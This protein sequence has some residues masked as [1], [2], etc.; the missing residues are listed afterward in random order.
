MC[1]RRYLV[2]LFCIALSQSYADTKSHSRQYWVD[3]YLSVSYP[4]KDVKVNSGYGGRKDPFSGN[5]THHSGLDLKANYER[6]MAMF[7]GEVEQV[8]TDKRSGHYIVLRHHIYTVSYCHLSKVLVEQGD[9]VYAGDVVGISGDT[10][11]STGPHLHITSKENGQYKDPYDLLLF[12][13][14]TREE[15]VKRLH[16][17]PK[18][19]AERSEFFETYGATAMKHQRRYGIPASVTLAQMAYESSWGTSD[20][21]TAGNNFFGIKC[22]SQWLAEGKP[23]SLHNDDRPNEKFCNFNSVE[24][25]MEYHARLLM[26]DHYKRCHEYGQ[27]DYHSWLTGIRSAGYATAKD[28]VSSCE[29]IIKRYKLYRYDQ[30]ALTL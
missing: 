5:K 12:V 13:R 28:Y 8:G 23:Y 27:T 2:F 4:L 6:V 30:K 29:K 20:L 16:T 15:C 3:R 9:V 21:A 22:S 10:G 7:D 1:F 11:R 24:D 26:G 17:Q 19:A 14:H 25:G 18:T